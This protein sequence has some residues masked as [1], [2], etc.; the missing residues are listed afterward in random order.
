MQRLNQREI[1]I[2]DVLWKSDIPLT[3]TE[4]VNNGRGLTQSTV[5]AVLRK[6]LKSNLVE[7]SGIT[8]SGKVLSRTYRP[9]NA[10]KEILLQNFAN[11]YAGFSKVISKSALCAAIMQVNRPELTK[12]EIYKLH[13]LLADFE[14]SM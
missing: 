5:I 10:S 11:E 3:S 1:D 12:D 2:L 7:V 6:L 13:T 8:H 14:N 4:I 9:T